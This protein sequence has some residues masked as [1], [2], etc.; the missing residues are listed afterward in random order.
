[1]KKIALLLVILFA[2]GTIL[3]AVPAQANETVNTIIN[4]IKSRG[5]TSTTTP[6]A[7]TAVR[8]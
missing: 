2:V 6:T 4:V 1:M 5:Q 7:S 3:A 8:G